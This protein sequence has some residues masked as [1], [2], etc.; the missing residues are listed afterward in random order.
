VRVFDGELKYRLERDD[1]KRNTSKER[2]IS[3]IEIP[4]WWDRTESSLIAT[5]HYFRP[6]IPLSS[7]G[8]PIPQEIPKPLEKRQVLTPTF[9]PTTPL[10][11]TGT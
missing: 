5:I 8:K 4:F 6:D 2:G 7:S 9:G 1:R 10:E 3:L 11:W